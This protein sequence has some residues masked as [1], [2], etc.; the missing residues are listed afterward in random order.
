MQTNKA[1]IKGEFTGSYDALTKIYKRYGLNGVYRGLRITLL[2]DSISYGAW[3]G[4]Y[5]TLKELTC[6]KDSKP[7]ILWYVFLGAL[8]GECFWLSTY[9]LDVCKTKLQSDS[10][11]APK[12]KGIVDVIAK[13]YKAEGI[14]GFWRG[15]VP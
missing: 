12:Y 3:F 8:A 10:F 7:S 1:G 11:T 4:C 13:T 2:R 5:E 15:I 6:P 14:A 9:P